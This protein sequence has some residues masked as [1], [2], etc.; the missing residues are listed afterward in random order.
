[1]GE[2][3]WGNMYRTTIL[4]VDSCPEGEPRGRLYNPG[5]PEGQRF[6]GVLDLLA[7]MEAML[8]DMRFPQSFTAGRT[9]QPQP[10]PAREAAEEEE[11]R[12]RQATFALRVLFRQNASWQGSVTWMET[13]QEASFRS[14]LDLLMLLRGALLGSGE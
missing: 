1:M 13:G 11:R 3:L 10:D 8:D 6:R 9:F 14:V 2:K 12:G 7:R 5:L 4:C